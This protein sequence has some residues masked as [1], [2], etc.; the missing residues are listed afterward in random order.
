MKWKDHNNSFNSWI[1]KKDKILMS[2]Y[3]PKPY[4]RSSKNVIVK[5]HLPNYATKSDKK[6]TGVDTSNLLKRLIYQA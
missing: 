1:D 4:E 2:Q 3:F 6:E 5:L